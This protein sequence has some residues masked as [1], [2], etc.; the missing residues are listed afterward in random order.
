MG[1][2]ITLRGCEGWEIDT[3]H[4]D[5]VIETITNGQVSTAA[6]AVSAEAEQFQ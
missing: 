2:S 4:S 1:V 5:E 6:L 3:G